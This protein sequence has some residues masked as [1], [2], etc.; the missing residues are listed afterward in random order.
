[1]A[2]AT[3]PE[4]HSVHDPCPAAEVKRPAEQRRQ[5]EAPRAAAKVPIGHGW[6]CSRPVEFAKAPTAHVSQ[7]D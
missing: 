4:S 1:M 5:R 2:N 6:H 7:M 3:V